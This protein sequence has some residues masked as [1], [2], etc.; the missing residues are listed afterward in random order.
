[1]VGKIQSAK[2]WSSILAAVTMGCGDKKMPSVPPDPG[3]AGKVTID[4]IDSD[5][6]GIRDDLQRWLLEGWKEPSQ[7]QVVR[8]SVRVMQTLLLATGKDQ[9]TA[10][11]VALVRSLDCAEQLLKGGYTEFSEDL[12]SR[13]LNTE[14][15]IDAY[16]DAAAAFDGQSFDL[17]SDTDLAS[18][19][20][21]AT[22]AQPLQTGGSSNP[23]CTFV[24]GNGM[25]NDPVDVYNS[26]LAL[27]LPNIPDQAGLAPG[28][29]R[30]KA[31]FQD[32]GGTLDQLIEVVRQKGTWDLFLPWLLHLDTA[33]E[34][35][36]TAAN[37][38]LSTGVSHW[39]E[40]AVAFHTSLYKSLLQ[41]GSKIVLVSHSQGNFYANEAFRRLGL[42]AGQKDFGNIQVATPANVVAAGGPHFTFD[43]DRIIE[44]VRLL[45]LG[46]AAPL[47]AYLKG[48]RSSESQDTVLGHSFNRAYLFVPGSR[49]A[50]LDAVV[51]MAKD[52]CVSKVDQVCSQGHLL[53]DSCG[54]CE[55]LCDPTVGECASGICACPSDRST[56]CVTEKRDPSTGELFR[57][58]SCFPTG[59]T[60]CFGVLANFCPSDFV[61]NVK[62]CPSGTT[63]KPI[64]I[65]G[66]VECCAGEMCE[67]STTWIPLECVRPV[68]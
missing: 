55:E 60:C 32:T 44:A 14:E 48:G 63:C 68:P 39:S 54:R 25:F 27:K 23:M 8:D 59:T 47:P 38:A 62:A 18:C 40:G 3:P 52:L 6:D 29:V 21:T 19:G 35:F 45:A 58:H 61:N 49:K 1:M 20:S 65:E 30:F 7:Q 57:R 16:F 56:I 42:P 13:A 2:F 24:F 36:Q 17:S 53:R 5:K 31:A 37:T 41:Q 15:R 33:P 26:L 50:I 10:A 28:S 64:G 9:A 34:W 12:R 67:R 46:P 43:D 51:A 4:G 22:S 66:D 11:T